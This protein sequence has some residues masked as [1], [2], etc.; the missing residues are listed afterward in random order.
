MHVLG[1]RSKT[2]VTAAALEGAD[3]LL[4]IGAFCI[5]VNQIDQA[6]C[7][8]RGV[9]VFNAPYSNT[10][11]V[12]ELAIGEIVALTRRLTEKSNAAHAGRWD[13]S[14]AGAH[15]IRGTTLGIVGYGAIG[16]Q[17][18]VLAESMGMSVVYYDVAEKLALGN[19]RRY[20]TLDELLAQ[21]DVVSLHVDG[22]PENRRLIGRAELAR[23]KPGALQIG[24][25]HV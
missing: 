22:R 3:K 13:K 9:A 20:R 23:M 10:R 15:E 18:S 25:A 1:I 4:A 16:S 2:K 17:L 11:S 14:A 5:G 24:R 7:S 12:V 19:A 21:A 8:A 6:A